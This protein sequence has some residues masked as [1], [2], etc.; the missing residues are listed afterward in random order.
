VC[1]GR[2]I[3]AARQSPECSQRAA[4]ASASSLPDGEAPDKL[5]DRADPSPTPSHTGWSRP[6]QG[7]GE[8]LP[9]RSVAPTGHETVSPVPALTPTDAAPGLRR[10]RVTDSAMTPMSDR[11]VYLL[12]ASGSCRGR[13]QPEWHQAAPAATPDASLARPGVACRAHWQS[14][15][16]RGRIALPG[17]PPLA[18]PGKLPGVRGCIAKLES[19]G[20]RGFREISDFELELASASL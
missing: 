8:V 6:V 13:C 3:S 5:G 12:A 7:N 10:Q 20:S 4:K 11:T 16:S 2:V 17:L 15:P 14:L 9:L 18:L 19:R 1:S